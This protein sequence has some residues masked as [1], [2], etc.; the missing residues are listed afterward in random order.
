[1]PWVILAATLV[2][3][4][5]RLWSR[6]RGGGPAP[7]P[8]PRPA[9]SPA[10][11]GRKDARR[12]SG[13]RSAVSGWMGDGPVRLVAVREI[14]ERLRSRVFRVGTAVL[15]AAAAAAVVI[16]ALRTTHH[17]HLT[18][19]TVGAVPA[20]LHT[21][22]ESTGA[23][24]GATVTIVPETDRAGAETAVRT[25]AVDMVVVDA[26]QILVRRPVAPADLSTTTVA[27]RALAGWIGTRNA[28][29]SAG[30]SPA[31]AARLAQPAPAPIVALEPATG[32][33]GARGTAKATA[34]LG[35]IFVFLLL[36]QYG[37]WILL[38]IV[39]EKSSR[40][41]EVLLSTMRP[42]QLLTGKVLG[43]GT[44]ALG[45]AALI[46]AVALG[47]AGAVGSDLVRGTAPVEVAAVLCWMVLGYLFY[48]WVY[49]AG[50]ALAE[51]QEHV[52]SIAFPLQL[53]LIVGYIASLTGLGSATTPIFVRIL[54]FLPPT[55]PFAMPVLVAQGDTTWWQ[56]LISVALTVIAT[57]G[58]AR[59][60]ATIYER[61]ILLTGHRV[62]VREVLA[63]RS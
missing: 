50:G 11:T 55:A 45:Q 25:A 34:T 28:L 56:F 43:I 17:G 37:T 1:M 47:L 8:G 19:G 20:E 24:L 22:L 27:A 26:E 36:S 53:P 9:S 33:G 30:L 39:E 32:H 52:Q 62:R 13:G 40:V 54:A 63:A 5:V 41:V 6:R 16:P 3:V 31:D 60:A 35:L 15:L 38:G 42:D 49:A 58:V 44:V 4:A 2:L 29:V 21:E 14:R 57:I 23:T 51:R 10:E 12:R 61:A 59:I 18:I 7:G 46:V 48:C